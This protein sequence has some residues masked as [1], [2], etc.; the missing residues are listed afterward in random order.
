[1]GEEKV[2]VTIKCAIEQGDVKELYLLFSNDNGNNWYEVEMEP[3]PESY[4]VEIPN[5]NAGTRILYCFRAIDNQ[6]QEFIEDNQGQYYTQTAKKK[7]LIKNK[8]KKKSL[9][10]T[11]KGQKAFTL[12]NSG[13]DVASKK[14]NKKKKQILISPK[15]EKF[16]K[17][18]AKIT[19][20]EVE[21]SKD[22]KIKEPQIKRNRIQPPVVV[23][24][25]E[26]KTK[27]EIKKPKVKRKLKK[28]KKQ[29]ESEKS[30]KTKAQSS[31]PPEFHRS[32]PPKFQEED[33]EK[34]F[35]TVNKVGENKK[36]KLDS[37]D[38]KPIGK[39]KELEQKKE[40][41][42]KF[43]EEKSKSPS[44]REKKSNNLGWFEKKKKNAYVEDKSDLNQPIVPKNPYSPDTGNVN[45]MAQPIKSFSQIIR[46]KP[47]SSPGSASKNHKG[48]V[49]NKIIKQC[50]KCQANL[51]QDWSICAICGEKI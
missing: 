21:I 45:E 11:K 36:E 2:P 39:D 16:G 29:E 47:T 26:R 33:Q 22:L 19:N 10:K 6:G 50:P 43:Q 46:F 17:S 42:Q 9:R 25:Q 31:L 24:G 14:K 40:K 18:K 27:Q 23:S 34:L 12:Q 3:S 5:V 8:N 38:F 37:D 48:S 4:S 44:E 7:L 20:P 1:M 28:I 30:Q 41:T 13:G 15:I 35:D 49:S 51:S 32:S